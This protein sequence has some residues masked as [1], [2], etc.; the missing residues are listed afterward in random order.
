M[1]MLISPGSLGGK[2]R[3][4]ASKS[5]AHRLLILAAFADKTCNIDCSSSSQDIDATIACLRALGARITHTKIGFRVVPIPKTSRFEPYAHAKLDCRESGS[6]LRFMLPV[7]AALG[8]E[9]S[10]IGRGRLAKRPLAQ[11]IAAL[12]SHGCNLSEF[13]SWPLKLTGQLQAGNYTL[14]GNVSSQYVTGL[15]LAASLLE[16]STEILVSEP[17]Q[18][19]PYVRLTLNALSLFGVEYEAGHK[20]LADGSYRT[21]RVFGS[22]TQLAAPETV[23]VEGDWSN[24]AFWL[25]AAAIGKLPISVKQLNLSSAQGDRVILAALSLFGAH[26]V[27]G[28]NT[29][30][31]GP[32]SLQGIR[33]DVSNCPDLVPPLAILGAC[34]TGTTRLANAGRLRLKESDRLQTVSATLQA[35]GAQAR[36]ETDDLLISGGSTLTGGVVDAA[37]DH[38]IAMM[39]A[40]LA[41]QCTGDTLIHGADC[42]AKSYPQFFKDFA[43]LGGKAQAQEAIHAL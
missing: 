13:G 18:S 4:I 3:S 28:N 35:L 15:L 19:E 32:A 6:T 8:A 33:I 11:L 30:T 26:V 40:I 7:A 21:Y 9:A 12:N 25:V 37:G 42:V 31:V 20:Q 23:R 2:L 17:F 36:I 43:L 10:F 34:A 38:R 16:G 5:V 41:T 29:A 14:P 1:D 24:A 27:R 39:A 22:G